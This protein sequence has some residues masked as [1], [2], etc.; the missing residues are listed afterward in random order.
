MFPSNFTPEQKKLAK[1]VQRN[2]G[3]IQLTWGLYNNYLEQYP[4]DPKKAMELTQAAM[5]VWKDFEDGQF[6][7]YPEI[8]PAP[9]NSSDS[10]FGVGSE[11][12]LAAMMQAG[13]MMAKKMREVKRD[14][15][16]NS[17]SIEEK[18]MEEVV[19]TEEELIAGLRVKQG[20]P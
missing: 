11:S 4:N 3:F 13:E 14:E 1:E 8:I 2:N 10:P 6:M 18:M 7:E 20:K 16:K 5:E 15:V 9:A 19:I 17:M 12:F